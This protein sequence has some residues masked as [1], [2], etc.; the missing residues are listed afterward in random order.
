MINSYIQHNDVQIN[1]WNKL[2]KFYLRNYKSL[3]LPLPN[4]INIDISMWN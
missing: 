1:I 2:K 4:L 3:N